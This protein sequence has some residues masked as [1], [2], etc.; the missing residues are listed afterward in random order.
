MRVLV[1]GAAGFVGLNVARQLALR[2]DDVFAVSRNAPDRWANTFLAG[3]APH[4]Q[5]RQA[6][7]TQP[8]ALAAATAADPIEAVVHAAVLTATT[9]T[10]EREQSVEIVQA[11][12]GGTLEALDVARRHGCRRF[13]YVSSSAALGPLHA[14]Q[15]ADESA[16]PRPDTLY[17]ITKHASELLVQRYGAVHAFSSVSVR[18]A[19]PYGPGERPTASRLRTSPL[20]E[21]LDAAQRGVELVTGPLEVARDWTWVEE[22]ARGIAELTHAQTLEHNLYHLSVGRLFTVGA[23]LDALRAAYPNLRHNSAPDPERIN[24]NIADIAPR[25]PLDSARFR[26]EFGWA[27]E[28]TLDD[29]LAR[30]V[31]WHEEKGPAAFP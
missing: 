7:L 18:I 10:V 6:D 28:V 4:V 22:T 13:V 9:A 29:G 14:G 20:W 2:G 12:I 11:N 21:W 23:A 27:P 19:Q 1:T 15:P 5:W 26:A 8:G 3:V 16:N 24:P 30:C 25:A 31:A 17:G